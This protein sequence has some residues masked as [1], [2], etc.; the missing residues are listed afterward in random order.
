[1]PRDFNACMALRSWV[2]MRFFSFLERVFQELFSCASKAG[3]FGLRR[4]A[5][6]AHCWFGGC[7]CGC[8]L[9]SVMMV[10]VGGSDAM[11]CSAQLGGR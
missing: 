5:R 2:M 8:G 6:L 1:M 10:L 9:L 4:S 7:C 3:R 11:M